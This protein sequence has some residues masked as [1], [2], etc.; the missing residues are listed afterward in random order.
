VFLPSPSLS[1]FL[2][3]PPLSPMLPFPLLKLNKL[4]CGHCGKVCGLDTCPGAVC[5]CLLRIRISIFAL[6][7]SLPPPPPP[8]YPPNP[9]PPHPRATCPASPHHLHHQPLSEY[10]WKLTVNNLKPH[11]A[12]GGTILHSFLLQEYQPK[13]VAKDSYLMPC[14]SKCEQSLLNTSYPGSGCSSGPC[15]GKQWEARGSSKKENPRSG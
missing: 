15:S 7:D 11:F 4:V 8:P 14:P 12:K 6:L 3:L 5:T 10:E 9:T 1:F 13:T 2:S